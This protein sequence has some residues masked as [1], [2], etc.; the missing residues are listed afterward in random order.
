MKIINLIYKLFIIILIFFLTI[1]YLKSS[2]EILI[3]NIKNSCTRHYRRIIKEY[4]KKYEI[5]KKNEIEVL[6]LNEYYGVKVAL[7]VIAKQENIYI[8]EFIN[9]YINLGV[10]KIYLYDNN[11]QEGEKFDYILKLEIKS[12]LV[13]VI[14]YRG[15]QKPQKKAYNDCY[16]NHKNNYDWIGFYDVD[17]FLFFEKNIS[18][19]KFLSLPQFDN[20]SSILINWRNYGDSENIRYEYKPVQ[21]RFKV[22]FFFNKT[23]CNNIYLCSSVKSIIRG[24]LNITWEH[25]PHFINDS[26]R[27]YPN[28]TKVV[29]PFSFPQNFSV[30]IKHFSTKSTE[31][32]LIKLIKGTVNSNI[33]LNVSSIKLWINVYYF[34]FNKFTKKKRRFL[35]K[36]LHVDIR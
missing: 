18:I 29:Q 11:M 15:I 3:K 17:E 6:K 1:K 19:N 30:Y 31:E 21:E 5:D 2:N 36:I 10:Q 12:G 27:C 8:K 14:N 35:Q 22:P 20:C 9:Y 13:E 26:K 34:F 25:F 16:S 4:N 7:C 23:N 33:T 32:Y 28:G 24:G